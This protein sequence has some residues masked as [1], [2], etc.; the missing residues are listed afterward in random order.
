RTLAPRS[1]AP[2]R[3]ERRY[4]TKRDTGGV[5]ATEREGA[6]VRRC[7]AGGAPD[8]FMTVQQIVLRGSQFDIGYGLACEARDRVGW[9]PPETGDRIRTRPRRA[10]FEANWRQQSA[11]MA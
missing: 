3:P 4:L 2:W 8:D 5:T 7:L 6:V 9:R 1:K 10:W 11:R